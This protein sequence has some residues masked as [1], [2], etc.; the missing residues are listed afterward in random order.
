LRVSFHRASIA[1]PGMFVA[2]RGCLLCPR[3]HRIE[4]ICNRAIRVDAACW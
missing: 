3:D 2:V 4:L 1:R